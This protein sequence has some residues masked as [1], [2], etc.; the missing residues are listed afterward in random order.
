MTRVEADTAGSLHWIVRLLACFE[1]IVAPIII[2]RCSMLGGLSA[3]VRRMR[4]RK[5][6]YA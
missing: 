5:V 3:S 6:R 4:W 2:G 1:V